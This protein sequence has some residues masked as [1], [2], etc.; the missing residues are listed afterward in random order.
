LL[1][2][3]VFLSWSASSLLVPPPYLLAIVNPSIPA[4][5]ACFGPLQE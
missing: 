5:I 2:Y 4:R 3:R 1:S